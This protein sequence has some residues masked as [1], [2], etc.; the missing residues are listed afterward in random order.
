MSVVG[1]NDACFEGEHVEGIK[2]LEISSILQPEH[3]ET[4]V[5]STAAFRERILVHPVAVI[6]EHLIMDERGLTSKFH[7]SAGFVHARSR[8]VAHMA[9]HDDASV[10]AC[11]GLYET[12]SVLRPPFA[13]SMKPSGMPRGEGEVVSLP[14]MSKP[15]DVGDSQIVTKIAV[16]P[17]RPLPPP[18]PRSPSP[19]PPKPPPPKP[20]PPPSPR[21]P[22]LP[23]KVPLIKVP[24]AP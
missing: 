11:V 14:R 3:L 21:S 24:L 17:P 8:P 6:H 16:P 20:P 19:P 23:I 4:V 13:R 9:T 10:H 1:A 18:S 15:P 5:Q 22:S 2:K 7:R 12:G